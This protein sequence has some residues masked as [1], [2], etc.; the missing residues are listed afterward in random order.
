[1]TAHRPSSLFSDPPPAAPPV[2][3]AASSADP[4]TAAQRYL[5]LGFS[6]IPLR[7]KV[8]AVTWRMYQQRRPTRAELGR[9]A[10]RGLF[11]NVGIVC[12]AVSGDLVVLDFDAPGAYEAFCARFPDLTHTYTVATGGGGWH[13]YLRVEALP[14]PQRGRGVELRAN[15]QQVAAPPGVHPTGRPYRVAQALDILRVPDLS[16][17][18]QWVCPHPAP[19]R[20][21]GQR[22]AARTPVSPALVAA[23][24]DHFRARGYRQKGD[25]L[26]GPCIYPERH[27]HRDHH[28]S[29]GFNTR[30]GYGYCFVC[31]SM[32]AKEMGRVLGLDTTLPAE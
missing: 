5:A 16:A 9:W 29:F 17:V 14:P 32:L 19:A 13:V 2:V 1:M 12:G 22:T 24:A 18:A 6:V 3:R 30:T 20:S 23:L 21:T 28:R 25:W 4:V 15:G 27:A 8:P 31:G 10:R 7:G 11:Q 26:N